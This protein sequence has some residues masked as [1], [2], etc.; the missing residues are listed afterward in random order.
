MDAGAADA[1][2]R[3]CA[4]SARRGDHRHRRRVH[5]DRRALQRHS[6][7][8]RAGHVGRRGS[9]ACRSRRPLSV[10]A[11][12]WRPRCATSAVTRWGRRC[13]SSSRWHCH[14]APGPAS[15]AAANCW[16]RYVTRCGSG[17]SRLPS[18]RS[19]S[20]GCA[21][22]CCSRRCRSCWRSTSSGRT[23]P[24]WT[25]S[26]RSPRPTRCGFWRPW[27]LS[28]SATS[29]LPGGWWASSPRPSRCAGCS[30]RRS[31]SASSAWWHRPPSASPR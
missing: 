4:P 21:P 28:C 2:C 12:P 30:P 18:R 25:S 17:P 29:V 7:R 3:D 14:R 15:A 19:A 1:R 5:L 13:P 6:G 31:R 27:W 22:E 11:G 9:A 20:N 10:P 8:E 26:A 24:A 16:S 23:W